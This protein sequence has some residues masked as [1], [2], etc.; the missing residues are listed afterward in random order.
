M[1]DRIGE[2]LRATAASDDTFLFADQEL[3]G[4][5]ARVAL[6]ASLEAHRGPAPTVDDFIDTIATRTSTSGRSIAVRCMDG[7]TVTM[8]QWLRARLREL[9]NKTAPA[10]K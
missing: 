8:S 10:K 7:T 4:S 6:V 3:P 2:L 1:P 9:D 5:M